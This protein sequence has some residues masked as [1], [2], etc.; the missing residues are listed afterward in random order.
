MAGGRCIYFLKGLVK[1]HPED[2]SSPVV[3]AGTGE[4]RVGKRTSKKDM[5]NKVGELGTNG[6]TSR[7]QRQG[8]VSKNFKMAVRSH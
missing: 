7:E 2:A 5:S 8:L 6:L 1:D 4:V 3:R